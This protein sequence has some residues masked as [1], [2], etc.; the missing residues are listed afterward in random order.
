MM[1][2]VEYLV[3]YNMQLILEGAV[4]WFLRNSVAKMAFVVTKM[5]LLVFTI[6]LPFV[7]FFICMEVSNG[8]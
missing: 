4:G 6:N 1:L 8:T 2:L 3:V 7:R 5:Q